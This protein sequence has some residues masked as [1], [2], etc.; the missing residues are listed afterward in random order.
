MRVFGVL[1]ALCCVC[2]FG[3]V[4]AS[5]LSTEI[6]M[7]LVGVAVGAVASVPASLLVAFIARQHA[8]PPAPATPEPRLRQA[9]APPPSVVIVSPQQGVRSKRYPYFDPMQEAPQPR[10]FTIL[11]DDGRS[12]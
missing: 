2:G 4:A 5:R 6:R 11:G 9:P 3:L 12:E 10:T 1:V 8:L 7:L